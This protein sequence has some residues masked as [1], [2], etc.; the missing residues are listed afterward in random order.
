MK[1][2]DKIRLANEAALKVAVIDDRDPA[3]REEARREWGQIR[4]AARDAF[5]AKT[6]WAGILNDYRDREG[7]YTATERAQLCSAYADELIAK[8]FV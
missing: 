4:K 6:D 5:L 3:A 2:A 1:R 8:A 7:F